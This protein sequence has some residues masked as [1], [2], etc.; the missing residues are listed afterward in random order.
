MLKKERYLI[1]INNIP[2]GIIEFI[3]KNTKFFTKRFTN[4]NIF[5]L[6]RE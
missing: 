1:G 5:Q 3:M 4:L 2:A 6:I